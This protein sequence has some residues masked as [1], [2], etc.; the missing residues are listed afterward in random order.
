MRS[1]K[2]VDERLSA[3]DVRLTMGGEPTFVSSEDAVAPE[4]NTAAL[5]E[6]KRSIAAELF[7]R[8]KERYAPLR[9]RAFRS[10]QVVSRRAAAALVAELLLAQGRRADLERRAR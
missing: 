1:G 5:G 4:W 7:R 6:N 3:D 10:G 9:A 8:L 2:R